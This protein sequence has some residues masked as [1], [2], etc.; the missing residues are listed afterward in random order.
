MNVHSLSFLSM[1]NMQCFFY[2][3]GDVAWH[4]CTTDTS[5][6]TLTLTL[7]GFSPVWNLCIHLPLHVL[8]VATQEGGRS[9]L[10]SHAGV[11]VHISSIGDSWRR[12]L[13]WA[14]T[15]DLN[16]TWLVYRLSTFL[17]YNYFF[18]GEGRKENGGAIYW[19]AARQRNSRFPWLT[20]SFIPHTW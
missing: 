11:R 14:T 20:V 1:Y 15:A 13:R 5:I 17:L 3:A 19:S 7:Q 2:V 8:I 12:R 9:S 10:C 16:L 4:R 18:V 6:N